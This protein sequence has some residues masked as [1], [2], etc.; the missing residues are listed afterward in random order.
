MDCVR[1][2]GRHT[3]AEGA[4]VEPKR[5]RGQRLLQP[6]RSIPRRIYVMAAAST[7]IVVLVVWCA[8][9]YTHLVKPFFLPSPTQVLR[10]AVSLFTEFDLLRDMRDSFYRV[11]VAFVL[12]VVLA[13]PIGLLMGTY[14]IAEAVISPINEFIRYMPVPAF[15]P[16]CILWIGIGNNS[17]IALIF[18]G[19]FFQLLVLVA[20]I[21]AQ[22]PG[23]Y[24]DASYTVGVGRLAVLRH[25]VLPNA[26]P[27]VFDNV[28]VSFGWAW[29]Y[30]LLAEI[31]GAN[32]GLGHMIMESQ[33]FLRT[34]NVI[35]GVLIIGLIGVLIDLAFRGAYAAL[36]PWTEKQTR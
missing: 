25:V 22:T 10:A 5:P 3:S 23:E 30:L 8:V 2:E 21:A 19:T 13:V 9:T 14:K 36:F 27:G 26:M 20:D 6:K 18:I 17:Q 1:P 12:S 11:T 16:L 28:R 35:A 32:T 4:D 7:F 33:R 31:V 29:S 15:I 34:D 24:L